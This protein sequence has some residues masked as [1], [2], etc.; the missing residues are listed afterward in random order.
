MGNQL[1]VNDA[2]EIV[3]LNKMINIF[4]LKNGCMRKQIYD[5]LKD[6]RTR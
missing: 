4:L 2:D 5:V 1:C 6:E 3:H